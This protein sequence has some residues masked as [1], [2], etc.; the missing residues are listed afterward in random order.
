MRD[1]DWLQGTPGEQGDW[2][3]A[4]IAKFED[5]HPDIHVEREWFPRADMHAK[6]VALAATGL[7]GT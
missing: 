5:A 1:H 2:Y 6:E 7:A 4:F 3:D